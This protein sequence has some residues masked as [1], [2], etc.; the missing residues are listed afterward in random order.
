MAKKREFG[1]ALRWLLGCACIFSLGHSHAVGHAYAH[2]FVPTNLCPGEN[3][4]IT[5]S[6]FYQVKVDV[7]PRANCSK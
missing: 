1:V 2:W 3:N 5:G 7:I 4:G 6:Q